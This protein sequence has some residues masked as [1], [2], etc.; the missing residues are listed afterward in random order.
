[1]LLRLVRSANDAHQFAMIEP[2]E[3]TGVASVDDDAA[4]TEIK[5]RVHGP[6]AFWT[7]DFPPQ[8]GG[9][10]SFGSRDSFALFGFQLFDQVDKCLHGDEHASAFSAR[11]E[12]NPGQ[13]CVP[14]RLAANGARE[15]R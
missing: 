3:A 15:W 9:I 12:P 5:V 2:V 14:E 4:P 10:C 13:C 1:M 8:L 7:T 11:L 6:M